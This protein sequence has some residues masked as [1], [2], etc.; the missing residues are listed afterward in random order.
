ML[1]AGNCES[2]QEEIAI[3]QY[4]SIEEAVEAHPRADVFINFASFRRWVGRSGWHVLLCVKVAGG[5]GRMSGE[6]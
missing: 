4:G 2:S 1:F 6:E 3:P 5:W